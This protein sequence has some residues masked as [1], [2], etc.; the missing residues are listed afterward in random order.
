VPLAAIYGVHLIGQ[1]RALRVDEPMLA[2]R[3]FKSNRDAGLILLAALIAGAW[4]AGSAWFGI[5]F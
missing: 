1:A 5:A 2:L 3:L 4:R